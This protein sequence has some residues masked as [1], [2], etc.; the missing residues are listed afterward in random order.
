VLDLATAILPSRWR[1][2]GHRLHTHCIG[3]ALLLQRLRNPFAT[4]APAD[5]ASARLGDLAEAILVCSR[6]WP[7]A[8]ALLNSRY[9]GLAL[10]WH[11]S[12]I[13]L[14]G[15]R[16]A[17]ITALYDHLTDAWT[18]PA[19]WLPP[20]AATATTTDALATL[21]HILRTT[22]RMTHQQVMLTPVRQALHDACLHL[23]AQGQLDLVDSTDDDL[24]R[25]AD[26]MRQELHAQS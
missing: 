22:Y 8:A 24:I 13:I 14:H 11:A 10:C 4:L 18:P 19:A 23:A 25:A 5:A 20:A 16:P 17:V 6:T 9:G 15:R 7:R 2:A 1:V 12:R 3:H 26:R 21:N